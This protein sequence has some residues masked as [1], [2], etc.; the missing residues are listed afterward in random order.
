[1]ERRSLK[2]RRYCAIHDNWNFFCWEIYQKSIVWLSHQKSKRTTFSL[3]MW[4][5][6]GCSGAGTRGNGVPTPFSRFALKWVRSCLKTGYVWVR[7]H[8][9]SLA[10]HCWGKETLYSYQI[11]AL[12][13]WIWTLIS[14]NSIS[15]QW[16][17][18][19]CFYKKIPFTLNERSL[20]LLYLV[21]AG[22]KV[23]CEN[24]DNLKSLSSSSY[25]KQS[26]HA[27]FSWQYA[28]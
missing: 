4:G 7:S 26:K 22:R 25:R 1:V 16:S 2:I 3:Q 23:W 27:L 17:N 5:R 19:A 21:C 9:F 10:L 15:L 11:Y 12:F 24:P 18:Q 13:W 20:G 28:S 8:T 6:Q 14:A